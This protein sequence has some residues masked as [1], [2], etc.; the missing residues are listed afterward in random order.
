MISASEPTRFRPQ[1]RIPLF[2]Q[3]RRLTGDRLYP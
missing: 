2:A 1:A 3:S